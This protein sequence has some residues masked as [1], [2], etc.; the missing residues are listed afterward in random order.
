MIGHD[1]AEGLRIQ[2]RVIMALMLREARTRYG[3]MKVGYLW[4]LVEPTIHI[5]LFSLLFSYRWVTVPLGSSVLL[6]LATGFLTFFGFRNVMSR[7][8]G[9]YGSN[10]ALL[11][12]PVV[13]V[14]DV[15]L[16]R[17][18]LELATWLTVTFLILGGLILFGV[19]PLPHDIPKILG[20][21]LALFAIGFG[22]GIVVGILS[23]FWATFGSLMSV[24][25]RLL[26]FTSALFFLPDAIPSAMRDILAWN[27]VL[28]G[29]TLFREGYY[30]GYDSHMLDEG[31][32]IVWAIGSVLCG[33]VVEKIARK[34]LRRLAT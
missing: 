27:P 16:G 31:Y 21:I 8:S 26:Y 29:I 22:A 23:E 34:P 30:Q 3:R 6:F 28:H 13:R 4:A 17:A 25:L 19:A 9:A 24:P 7:T 1:L 18:L 14:M 32:L 11:S 20:A 10:E 12:F 5:A 2:G 15:F 33:L